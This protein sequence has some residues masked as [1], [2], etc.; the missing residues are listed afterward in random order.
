[1]WRR[2]GASLSRFAQRN[3][4]LIWILILIS[5]L[6][7][8]FW[9]LNPSQFFKYSNLYIYINVSSI[10]FKIVFIYFSNLK[11]VGWNHSSTTTSFSGWT[12]HR[13]NTSQCIYDE[14]MEIHAVRGNFGMKLDKF[15]VKPSHSPIFPPSCPLVRSPTPRHVC[16]TRENKTVN[17]IVSY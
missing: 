17:I 8:T 1:M 3:K 2:S 13:H 11:W 6:W 7:Y 10:R 14:D 16:N 9:S 4:F 15:K 5:C 12:P